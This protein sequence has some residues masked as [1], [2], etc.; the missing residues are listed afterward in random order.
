MVLFLAQ[1]YLASPTDAVSSLLATPPHLL[2][3]LKKKRGGGC[4]GRWFTWRERVV[5]WRSAKSFNVQIT[6]RIA[7]FYLTYD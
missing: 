2:L 5:C 1:H 6:I 3:Y 7:A 4:L